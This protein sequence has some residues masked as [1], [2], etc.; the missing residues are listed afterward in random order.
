MRSSWDTSASKRRARHG[1]A[2]I[3]QRKL[4]L[5]ALVA[6][7]YA[8]VAGGPFGLEEVVGGNGYRR[9]AAILCLTPLLWAVP[10]A[11]MV[12]ELA[13]ALPENG[14]FYIWARRAMGGF[15]GFQEAWLTLLGS[16]F[17]MAVY[18]ILF[19]ACLGHLWPALAQGNM[20]FLLGAVM[21]AACVGMNLLG[22]HTV[23][24]SSIGFVLLLLAPFAVLSWLG[25][26]APALAAPTAEPLGKSDLFGGI[27][28]AMWNYMGWDN[29][30]LIAGDVE[31]AR[32]NYLWAMS[33]S[34][35]AV[36]I[37]YLVPVAAMAHAGVSR[38]AW[39]TGSW[40]NIAQSLGGRALGVAVTAA[41]VVAAFSTFNA[42]VLSLS[43]L[44]WAMARDGLLPR[45]FAR[46]NRYG[47]PWVA[48]LACAALWGC[49]MRLGF[50]R[51]VV[52]DVVLTGLSI[53]L[54]FAALVTLRVREPELPRP[55]RVPGGALG[56]AAVCAPPAVLL[57]VSAVR[58]R[59]EHIGPVNAFVVAAGLIVLGWVL[60]AVDVR[61]K[62]T[63]AA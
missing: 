30:G 21:I 4:G 13:G 49:A 3:R 9:A 47:A 62:R 31:N 23:G 15:W 39:E 6:S 41:G 17:D 25:F 10:T 14:G 12:A 54:E 63:N 24:E 32:K 44:P 46:E 33:I 42:L 53:L 59:H 22:T 57:A 40:V 35:V 18:P 58:S 8:M 38:A 48:I 5:V 26:H 45:V 16:I 36:T 60:Y 37:T 19:S 34:V 43:R 1:T 61:R 50:E 55:F 27:L 52:L 56:L 29:A 28:I 7:T 2:L 20:P 51:T 11:L